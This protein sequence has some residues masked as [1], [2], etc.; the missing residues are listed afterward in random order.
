MNKG[1]P[2]Y[3]KKENMKSP[4]PRMVTKKKSQCLSAGTSDA[5]KGT[6]KG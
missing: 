6:R 3:G 1:K 4:A 2:M 5:R